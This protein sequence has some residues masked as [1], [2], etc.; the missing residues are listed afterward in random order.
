MPDERR[1]DGRPRRRVIVAGQRARLHRP[2]GPDERQP[3]TETDFAPGEPPA[4]APP[5]AV[6]A[7][8]PAVAEPVLPRQPRTAPADRAGPA[9]PTV[10]APPV[11]AETTSTATDEPGSAPTLTHVLPAE[12]ED[13]LVAEPVRDGRARS[14]RT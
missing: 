14:R 3:P 13:E 9:D 6:S 5:P 11:P 2:A 10:T 4:V 12:P 8:Q 7:Q 1:R